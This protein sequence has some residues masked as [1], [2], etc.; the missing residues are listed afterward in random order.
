M[1]WLEWTPLSSKCA[2]PGKSLDDL[3]V[4]TNRNVSNQ[5]YLFYKGPS[6]TSTLTTIGHLDS[7]DRRARYER[8]L[9]YFDVL[10]TQAPHDRPAEDPRRLPAAVPAF[11]KW[12]TG[13]TIAKVVAAEYDISPQ[14]VREDAAMSFAVDTL[15]EHV[16]SAVR[17]ELL[18]QDCLLSDKDIKSISRSAPQRMSFAIQQLRQGCRRPL[19]VKTDVFD[20]VSFSEMSSRIARADGAV[21]A[22]LSYFACELCDTSE[23]QL[24]ML[25]ATVDRLMYALEASPCLK[26]VPSPLDRRK[27]PKPTVQKHGSCNQLNAAQALLGKSLRD[28]PRLPE[29]LLPTSAEVE[30]CCG[31]LYN[32]R[33]QIART[34]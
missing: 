12:D 18:G 11:G 17:D 26:D 16:D 5:H 6:M 30:A 8:G 29:Q 25:D 27:Q 21:R 22:S 1:S 32:L 3:C 13:W 15:S 2:T 7:V 28:V 34:L 19:D 4:L 24:Q 31:R 33:G 9:A 20:T 23:A 10:N 14:Q